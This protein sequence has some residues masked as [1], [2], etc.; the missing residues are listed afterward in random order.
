MGDRD[1]LNDGLTRRALLGFAGKGAGVL[2]L[3]GLVGFL[4]LRRKFY[5]PPGTLPEEAF[6]STC[7]RCDKC[8]RVC[9]EGLITPVLFTESIVNA[10][11]PRLIG[12]CPR[13][14]RCTRTCPT[15]ALRMDV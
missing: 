15:G 12:P 1:R 5:R 4:D 6:L 7:V 2:A 3:G 8:A 13:C 9:P 10:G 14:L 11:T